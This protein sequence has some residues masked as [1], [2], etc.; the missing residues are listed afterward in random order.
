MH[1]SVL[2]QEVIEAIP[3]NPK[4]VFDGTLGAGGHAKSILEKYPSIEKYVGVDKD[5]DAIR[6]SKE[7][8]ENFS[9]KM[10][11]VNSASGDIKDI[12]T[13][14][15]IQSFDVVFMDLGLSSRQ[16][17]ESGRGFTFLKDEPLNM[18]MN[19]SD[20]DFTA[21]NIV[22]TWDEEDIANVLYAYADERF[23][24]QIARKIVKH[25]DEV[26]TIDN[27]HTLV[28]IVREAIPRRFQSKKTNPA[29]KTF[30]ALRIAVNGELEEAKK[31]IRD[32]FDLLSKGGRLVFIS[33]H[34]LEDKV[35]KENFKEL[36]SQNKAVLIN[37]KP[38]VPTD[39]EIKDNPRSRSA[40]LRI[41]EKC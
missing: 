8:L 3:E 12:A 9:S 15:H 19:D 40:K 17:E 32:G 4:F 1:I 35:V 39:S 26:G 28:D 20:P 21:W 23:S 27:T 22:N 31:V 11:F 24:R 18:S 2:L 30:Q 13:K 10:V 33:F 36:V 37:K 16:L 29:T 25:R 38:I 34:S 6:Y 41:L 14:N 7:V 5:S